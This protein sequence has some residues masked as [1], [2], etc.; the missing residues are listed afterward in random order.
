[1]C[2]CR[3]SKFTSPG[4]TKVTTGCKSAAGLICRLLGYSRPRLQRSRRLLLVY[5]RVSV[6]VC[7]QVVHVYI[8]WEN[9]WLLI[10]RLLLA[11]F[12]RLS[13]GYSQ[14]RLPHRVTEQQQ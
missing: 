1:M 14:S 5:M 4:R 3:L 13:P 2:V 7:L 11:W 8:V 10:P 12:G 9:K 6:F